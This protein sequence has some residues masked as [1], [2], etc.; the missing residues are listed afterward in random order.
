M[1]LKTDNVCR[2]KAAGS[3][4]FSMK[5]YEKMEAFLNTEWILWIKKK[6]K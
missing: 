3:Q 6:Q 2:D 5:V 1:V 4:S